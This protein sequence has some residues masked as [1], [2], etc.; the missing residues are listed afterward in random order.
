MCKLLDYKIIAIARGIDE[1][2]IIPTIQALIDGGIKAVE[3]PLS[4]KSEEEY[5]KTLRI[6]KKVNDTFGE[7]IYLG[8]GT[9]L[10]PKEVEEAAEMGAEYMISPNMDVEVIKKTKELGK[11]SMPGALTITE[12]LTAYNAGADVVKIFPAGNFGEGYIKALHGPCDF[13]PY[14][15][16]GGV[17]V[18]NMKSLLNAGYNMVAVGGNLVSK[19][20]IMKEDYDQITELAKKYVENV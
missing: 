1:D 11:G 16:V 8:A 4:H 9:V 6:I 20:L 13:V 12:V 10:S 15:A 17:N 19:E 7:K 18:D 5:K 3:L 14:A 2:H